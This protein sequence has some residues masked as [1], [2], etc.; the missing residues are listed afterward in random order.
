MLL[1]KKGVLGDWDLWAVLEHGYCIWVIWV[2]GMAA[3][4]FLHSI[5]SHM[6]LP[7]IFLINE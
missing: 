3:F 7:T 4:Y 6:H 5:Q 1:Y 2:S